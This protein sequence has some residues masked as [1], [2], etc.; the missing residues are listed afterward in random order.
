MSQVNNICKKPC[1]KAN[2]LEH[3]HILL[4]NNILPKNKKGQCS[5]LKFEAKKLKLVL[6][7]DFYIC[8]LKFGATR[9][10]LS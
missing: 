10:I 7:A 2:T 8:F 3:G 9:L 1:V 5:K 6:V 4:P